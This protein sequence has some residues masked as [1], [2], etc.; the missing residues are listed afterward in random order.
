MSGWLKKYGL[1]L[2]AGVAGILL[3][4][5][6]A[7][8][9]SL[10]ENVNGMTLDSEGKVI[11]FTGMV[12]DDDGKVKQLL[13]R[14]DKRPR[15]VDFQFDGKGQTLIPG[16][17]DAH[18]HVMDMGF[19]ALTL[20]LSG[21]RSLAEA[22]AAIAKYAADNPN[23]QWILGS[24][25]NQ[26]VWGLGRFPTAAEL[27]AVVPDRPV[28]LDRVDAH[29]AW[30]NSTAMKAAGVSAASKSPSG[31]NIIRI[32]GKPSGVFVDAAM[33]LFREAIPAPRPVERDLA[34]G[35][36]QDILLANGVTSI[37]DMGTTM[38]DWQS[39]RRAGDK[40]QL[41]IRII[42]YAAEIDNMV[43]IAGPG[44]SPWLYDDHLK[45]AGVKLYVD[46]A[47]GSRGASLK[48]PYADMPGESGLAMLTSAQLK[49]KMSR[50][51]MD[52]FQTA[53]HAIGDKANDEVLS[54]IEELRE[55]YKGDRRWRVEH[56]QIIDP[57]DIGRFAAT[58]TIASMQPVHQ[59]SDRLMAEAR[60]GPD[61]LP[62]AYA[63]KSLLDSGAILAFGTDV[64]VESSEP[65]P[66]LAA[67][68]T[69]EDAAGQPFGGWMPEERL[70]RE[71]AWQAY[72]NGA[73]YAAFAEDRLGSLEPGK[74]ADFLII[75]RDLMLATP[76]QIRA[77]Q[78][79]QTWIDGKPVF[80]R[81]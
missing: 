6:A 7:E 1:T 46:G 33:G 32:G 2:C 34:L 35:K 44:P 53:V 10:I 56:A 58:G 68:M 3:V 39:Y 11:R 74:R 38:Q 15:D 19:G 51:A 77:T 8:A 22:L 12:I 41:K 80:I 37:A 49:N 54:A 4:P 63:W 67:A 47:L 62:G 69:R 23:R 75:D 78:V 48:Q 81:K 72:T 79:L 20:D 70:S 14:R 65:F 16:F 64:P 31:G 30:V 55:T 17:F 27:D 25:W 60:L 52:G 28:F 66:G 5:G 45:L 29:A 43:A 57:A 61:R 9:D 73:A 26:E 50:A 40:G 42:S 59:T 24:G 18:G 13:D 21:T 71:Q 36:A 76:A